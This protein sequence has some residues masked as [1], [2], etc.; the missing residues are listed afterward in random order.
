MLIGVNLLPVAEATKEAV[1]L[2]LWSVVDLFHDE[3]TGARLSPFT[4]IRTIFGV[5][6]G[7]STAVPI[8]LICFIGL[9]IP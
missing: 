6:A 3:G 1:I 2:T 4:P 9:V 5:P 7:L 8:F